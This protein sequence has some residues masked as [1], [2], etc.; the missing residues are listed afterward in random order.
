MQDIVENYTKSQGVYPSQISCPLIERSWWEQLLLQQ[1][2][3]FEF[4]NTANW[5]NKDKLQECGRIKFERDRKNKLQRVYLLQAK[6]DSEQA[7]DLLGYAFYCY[8][9]QYERSEQN[10]EGE[11]KIVL[12]YENNRRSRQFGIKFGTKEFAVFADSEGSTI[13][14]TKTKDNAEGDK[15]GN[16]QKYSFDIDLGSH[17]GVLK[18][19]ER[20]FCEILKGIKNECPQSENRDNYHDAFRENP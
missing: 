5:R 2:E 7:R 14:L 6:K 8:C 17:T 12:D 1:Q 13:T 20:V 9:K 4:I 19:F 3:L 15:E 10:G 11:V 18:E 16:K